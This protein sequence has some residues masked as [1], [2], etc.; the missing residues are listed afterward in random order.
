M[1]CSNPSLPSSPLRLELF[2]FVLKVRWVLS[3]GIAGNCHGIS[4]WRGGWGRLR[5]V[6]A[7]F[8]KFLSLERA[9][10][11]F[12]EHLRAVQ[13][14]E[15]FQGLQALLL[16]DRQRRTWE[17]YRPIYAVFSFCRAPSK[18]QGAEWRQKSLSRR[19]F[20]TS[21]LPGAPGS[22]REFW[23]CCRVPQLRALCGPARA[24]RSKGQLP[25]CQTHRT[26]EIPASRCCLP[27]VGQ[28]CRCSFLPGNAQRVAAAALCGQCH[29][30]N[31]RDLCPQPLEAAIRTLPRPPAL[32]A[33]QSC[34]DYATPWQPLQTCT[35]SCLV[36][37]D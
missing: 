9:E 15:G 32:I 37:R 7:A 22:C 19:G 17:G 21:A 20:P 13:R 2:L 11:T 14:D 31:D 27:F 5:A 10:V 30:R 34:P 4:A 35:C 1:R 18:L 29:H 24:A 25:V 26:R 33:G 3:T 23:C 8:P 12:P 28:K 6:S 36:L 16:Q